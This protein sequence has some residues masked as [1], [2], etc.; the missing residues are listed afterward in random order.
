MHCEVVNTH[1]EEK[2]KKTRHDSTLTSNTLI[3]ISKTSTLRV[4]I[5][6]YLCIK[7]EKNK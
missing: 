4:S 2:A 1:R 7:K 3:V 6:T 5:V